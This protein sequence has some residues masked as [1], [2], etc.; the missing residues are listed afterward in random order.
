MILCR[1]SGSQEREFTTSHNNSEDN[2]HL[3]STNKPKTYSNKHNSQK[4]P[5]KG[6]KSLPRQLK[7]PPTDKTKTRITKSARERVAYRQN[8]HAM[9][10]VYSRRSGSSPI[11]W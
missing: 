11:D 4:G 2:S 5:E 9:K 6:A 7:T 1:N 3:K 8:Q 10:I